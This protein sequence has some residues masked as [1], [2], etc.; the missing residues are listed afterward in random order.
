MSFPK[1]SNKLPFKTVPGLASLAGKKGG[2]NFTEKQRLGQRMAMLR[3]KAEAGDV[4]ATKL[5]EVMTSPAASA[6][7]IQKLIQDFKAIAKQSD[8]PAL[9]EK[10]IRMLID[11]HK[12]HFGD[13]HK[14]ESMNM[15]L[16]INAELTEDDKEDLLELINEHR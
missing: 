4:D 9:H 1:G 5:Y 16:N 7:D 12:M 11:W 2:K 3:K 15:N 13:K 14:V 10:T 8:N 6:L